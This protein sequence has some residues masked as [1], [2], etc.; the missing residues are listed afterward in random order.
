MADTRRADGAST[1]HGYWRNGVCRNSLIFDQT[2]KVARP[3]LL[4]LIVH[5]PFIPLSVSTPAI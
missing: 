3:V 5:R 2:E 1:G 4:F